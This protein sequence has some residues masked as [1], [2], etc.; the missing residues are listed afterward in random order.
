MAD[1]R[2][3][4]IAL[5]RSMELPLHEVVVDE[6]LALI[7]SELGHRLVIALVM[8]LE[9]GV[10]GLPRAKAAKPDVELLELLRL[11]AYCPPE[12]QLSGPARRE[13]AR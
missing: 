8:L 13:E 5:W 7:A 12:D 6:A 10:R 4:E 2:A 3:A 1:E 9:V 11:V